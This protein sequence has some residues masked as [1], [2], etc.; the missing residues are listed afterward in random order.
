MG[1]RVGAAIEADIAEQ[2]AWT[3]QYK[4]IV[5]DQIEDYRLEIRALSK[6]SFQ[7]AMEMR[8][9]LLQFMEEYRPKLISRRLLDRLKAIKRTEIQ[10]DPA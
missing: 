9:R 5:R 7:E 2:R 1:L 6:T 3:V 10:N 8:V 4:E